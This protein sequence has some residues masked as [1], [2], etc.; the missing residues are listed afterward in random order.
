MYTKPRIRF[1]GDRAIIV[2]YGEGID[3]TVNEKVRAMA[4]MLRKS[5]PRGVE[6][7]IPAYRSLSLLYNPLMVSTDQIAKAIEAAEKNL[8]Q[9]EIAEPR[10]VEIPVCYGGEFGPDLE[11]VA[12]HNSLDA[13]EV[14]AV[15]TS[16]D[17]HIYMIGFA[18]GFCYLG[19]L[20]RRLHTPR[21]KTPR[22]LLPAGS[23]GI[24]E[25]QTGM[26]PQDSPGGWQIIGRTPLRLF[27]PWREEPF[28]YR[29]GDRIRFVSVTEEQFHRVYEKE[30]G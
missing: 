24:A 29:A 21:R 26:Y 6:A 17:Y 8:R 2:E 23:V 4:A 27:A 9:T 25:S 15:H 11:I 5:L 13:G 19:G 14:I 28:L 18:P 10:I 7:I 22:T 20:D 16:V 3:R 12:D 30:W 1:C